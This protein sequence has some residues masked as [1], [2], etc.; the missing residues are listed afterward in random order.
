[1]EYPQYQRWIFPLLVSVW[2][3]EV[4]V[5]WLEKFFSITFASFHRLISLVLYIYIFLFYICVGVSV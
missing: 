1:M 3:L 4:K 2:L 5:V